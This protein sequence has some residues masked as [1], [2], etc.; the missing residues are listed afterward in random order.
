MTL[1]TDEFIRRFFFMYYLI[2]LYGYATSACWQQKPQRSHYIMPRNP[3]AE[4]TITKDNDK[5][6]DL[7]GTAVQNY[8]N[9]CHGLSH[10]SERKNVQNRTTASVRCNSRRS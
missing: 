8:R 7:A 9:R 1:Q 6:G 3:G 2:A 4:K 10:L 5:K